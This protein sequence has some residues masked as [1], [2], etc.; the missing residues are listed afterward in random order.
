MAKFNRRTA[1]IQFEE[2]SILP[3][4]E[5]LVRLDVDLG[6]ALSFQSL[7]VDD[8]DAVKDAYRRFATLILEWNVEDDDGTAIAVDEECLF[9]AP[10]A[11]SNT[12]IQKWQ[13]AIAAVPAPLVKPSDNGDVLPSS[14]IPMTL[15]V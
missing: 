9:K 15:V 11:F 14:P 13:E 6:V 5:V 12:L 10:P 4:G 7:N 1:R 8:A 2:D 3:G